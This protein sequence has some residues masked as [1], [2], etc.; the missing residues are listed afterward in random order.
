MRPS[1]NIRTSCACLGV[2][3]AFAAAFPVIG[4]QWYVD[5]KATG[6]S[7]GKDWTNAWAKL[8]SIVWKNVNP[9]D[10]VYLAGGR[11]NEGL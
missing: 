7:T 9:G 8:S 3:L 1:W 2:W 10:T 4:A 6:G 5:P 11:Y